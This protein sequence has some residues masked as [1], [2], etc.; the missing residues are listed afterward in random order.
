[1]TLKNRTDNQEILLGTP[2][3]ITTRD[4]TI[5]SELDPAGA[6]PGEATAY[7]NVTMAVN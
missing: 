2:V 5:E 1:M 7:L 4:M 6:T 3:A